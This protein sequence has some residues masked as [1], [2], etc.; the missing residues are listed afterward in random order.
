MYSSDAGIEAASL[1]ALEAL[2]RTIYPSETAPPAGLAET[3]I[4]QSLEALKEPEKN[5]APGSAKAL[6]A[7]IRANRKPALNSYS[8]LTCAA[9]TGAYALSRALPQLFRQFDQPTLPS[10]R[11]PILNYIV[12][13]LVVARS[14]YAAPD[15][16]RN[17]AAE[18]SLEPFR[19]GLMDVLREGLRTNG[20]KVP[21]IKG[22][23][24]LAEIPGFLGKQEVEDIVHSMDDMLINEKDPE[25]R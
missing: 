2:L 18:R 15:T 5:N 17:Q 19:N 10:H 14:V 25:V 6:A 9:K 21:A 4:N 22:S 23:V 24:A 1:S 7:M 8:K 12:T 13:F 20:L 16:K 11:E 3:I